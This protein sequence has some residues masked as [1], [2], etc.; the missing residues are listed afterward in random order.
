MTTKDDNYYCSQKFTWLTVQLEKKVINSCCTADEQTI[1]FDWLEKNPGMLFNTPLL[2]KE[3]KEMLDNIPVLSC[4][5]SCWKPEHEGLASRRLMKKSHVITHRDVES[6]PTDLN[7]VLS[8]VC[9]LTCSYCCKQYSSA[10]AR[11]LDKNGNYNIGQERYTLNDKDRIF[12]NLSVNEV[13]RSKKFQKLVEEIKVFNGV[14]NVTFSGGEPLLDKSFPDLLNLFDR[15]SCINFYTGLGI[16]TKRLQQ[17]LE[18]IKHNQ[19]LSI[20]VSAENCNKLY[21]FNRY[22]NSYDNFLANL[23]VLDRS[24]IAWNFSSVISNLT[25]FGMSDFAKQFSDKKI[26]YQ[27][28]NDPDFLSVNVLDQTSKEYLIQQLSGSNLSCQ[29]ELIQTLS[30]PCSDQ[31]S[32]RF[33]KYIKEFANRRNL[34]LDIYPESM[35]KWIDAI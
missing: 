14:K 17:Q 24:G 27:F 22:G 16:N 6:S 2:Q 35:L 9:N 32:D 26:I 34:S 31:Q 7:I 1:D 5:K 12:L 23:D 28:C 30:H 29:T 20:T 18:K 13:A 11:D 10:W 8:S 19:N 25:V 33:S 4:R 15:S 21:E 3:R